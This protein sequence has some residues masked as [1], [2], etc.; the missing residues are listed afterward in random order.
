M[1]LG[2]RL[3]VWRSGTGGYSIDWLVHDPISS[4]PASG[5][6]LGRTATPQQWRARHMK[7]A[8]VLQ[9]AASGR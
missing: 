2:P 1:A 3:R 6:R 5:A 4:A 8:I 7:T 9:G